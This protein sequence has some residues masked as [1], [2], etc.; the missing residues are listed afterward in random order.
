MSLTKQKP[1]QSGKS[2]IGTDSIK[3]IG[4]AILRLRDLDIHPKE[5]GRKFEIL[6]KQT[7]PIL[8]EYE[9]SKVW[10]FADWPEREK[11]T[12]RSAKDLGIDLVG[13]RRGG[14]WVAIQCKCW[15]SG[16]KMQ[17][18]DLRNFLV[19]AA[20]AE[21]F[22]FDLLL[23]ITTCQIGGNVEE[24]LRSKGGRWIPYH[25]RHYDEPIDRALRQQRKPL[26]HQ[27]E[28]IRLCVKGL[29]NHDR[30]RLIMA[31]GTGKTFTALCI[32]EEKN[33]NTNRVLF[34]APSIALVGQARREWLRHTHD[35]LENLIVCSDSSSGKSADSDSSGIDILQLECPVT[36][37]PSQIAKFLKGSRDDTRRVVFCTFQSLDKV[38]EAQKQFDA[39]LF[40]LAIV[41]EA[42]KTVGVK[43]DSEKEKIGFTAIHDE[44]FIGA[45]KRLYMTATP[46]VYTAQSMDIRREQGI[47]LI[48]MNN[49]EVFGNEF[50][51][52]KFKEAVN[53]ESFSEEPLLSDYRVVVLGIRDQTVSPKLAKRFR[54]EDDGSV[55]QTGLSK[56]ILRAQGTLLALNGEIEGQNKNTDLPSRL[57]SS[58][59]FCNRIKVSRWYANALEDSK[60][61]EL[62]TRRLADGRKAINIS[63]QHLDGT[64]SAIDRANALEA[65]RMSRSKDECRVI[66]NAKLFS[67]GV[68]V[69]TLD[70][71]IFME[72]RKSQIDV[73]QAVGRVMRK[74]EGKRFGYIILPVVIPEKGGQEA[75]LND[76]EGY[77]AIGKVLAAL[78][79][80]DE[81]LAAT[82][83]R[84]IR[85]VEIN[86][87]DKSTN[88]SEDENDNA[89]STAS[90]SWQY[91]LFNEKHTRGL[92]T[93]LMDKMG[94]GNKGLRNANDIVYSVEGS[95]KLLDKAGAAET[96]GQVL[97]IPFDGTEKSRKHI[98][99][100]A[101][102][103]IQNACLLHKRLC[104]LPQM[105]NLHGVEG[106][107]S[108][109]NPTEILLNDWIKILEK[110]YRPIFSP[111]LRVLK[112]LPDR[113]E[114]QQGIMQAV[115][116]ANELASDLG[117][118]GWDHAGPLYHKIL[119][120]AESDGAFYTKN[121]AALLLAKLAINKEFLNWSDPKV[122]ED[123]KLIDPACGTGTL[124]MAAVKTLKDRMRE[125]TGVEADAKIHKQLVEQSVH[126]LDINEHAIQL[127][128][129]NLTLGAPD[130]DYR[131]M[132]LYPM[133]HGVDKHGEAYAGSLELLTGSR[134]F[135]EIQ[136]DNTIEQAGGKQIDGV[137]RGNDSDIV[138]HCNL[139]I[140]NPPFTN[141]VKRS[142]RF[143]R[144]YK[145]AM[146]DREK[147]LQ[148]EIRARQ[149]I[150]AAE[151]I[152]SNSVRTFFTPLADKLLKKESATLAKIMPAT[153][154]TSASGLAERKW[155]AQKF[156]IESLVTCHTKSNFSFSGNTQIHE[157]LMVCRRS[158]SSPS[159]PPT[160]IV[161]LTKM[162][163]NAE[164]VENLLHLIEKGD[165]EEWGSCHS[166]PVEKI[167]EGNWSAIQWFD[168][169]LASVA[170][171]LATNEFLK[172]MQRTILSG[173]QVSDVF[174]KCDESDTK[175]YYTKSAKV[176]TQI[177]GSPEQAVQ[178]REGKQDRAEYYLKK[179]SSRFLVTK[180]IDTHAGIITG[181]YSDEPS[182]GS[183]WQ[184]V[185]VDNDSEAKALSVWWNSTPSWLLLLNQRST[186]L[187]WPAWSLEQLRSTPIPNFNKCDMDILIRTFENVSGKTLK[188]MREQKDDPVRHEI[189]KAAAEI[190]RIDEELMADWRNRL[191]IE[192]TISGND[193]TN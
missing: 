62:T 181:I 121:V 70:A 152:D 164:D 170:N 65:L 49:S 187:T 118:F 11:F 131:Q 183:G 10:D 76:M 133:K 173:R 182:L 190:L 31:C 97:D 47:T 103:L 19:D 104:E 107:G 101:A 147:Y 100:T 93:R 161:V 51:R 153:A 67:E 151:V 96:L 55:E 178:P 138:G 119:G 141:N 84:F 53:P 160:K 29:T 149:G 13:Y 162:P 140:M 105:K 27:E 132:N 92:F 102:L 176:R 2:D 54:Q 83:H 193:G 61:K 94:L 185:Q 35:D 144:E 124:L 3:T 95:A 28:A 177:C 43:H 63:T 45:N 186:K 159:H 75:L 189:D 143:G 136:K 71:V 110:D 175:L 6:V 125:A 116:C 111:A 12:Q 80:H 184:P 26:P 25:I 21:N 56:A 156:H 158:S 137:H 179:S 123:F 109:E 128:A 155:L 9:I 40:D 98:C 90:T 117:D 89:E 180:R 39:P 85:Y 163:S 38:S 115:Q 60:L 46:K 122:L 18:R 42:H 1:S 88:G 134:P 139:V 172:P 106:L 15:D 36:T 168:G 130:I 169:E 171:T 167:K 22:K 7:L 191:A 86:M 166:W 165:I 50:Y 20:P 154:C 157:C 41:D 174:E 142:T 5:L 72:P 91:D 82:P 44:N 126:G 30:G 145:K 77:Q 4:D 8:R 87:E 73:V 66:M 148:I 14:G 57:Y 52:L 99:T 127:A 188:T 23:L 129:S 74:A 59:G 17:L 33:L 37:N 58:I 68:D 108:A 112:A 16:R 192:P 146:S 114:A 34:I 79:S 32:A 113:K 64:K 81:R 135:I 120:T 69:P 24:T 48:D 150:G 78:Q